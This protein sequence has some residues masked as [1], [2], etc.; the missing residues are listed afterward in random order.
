MNPHI[1]ELFH[2]E[3]RIA[4]LAKGLPQA[5]EMA[6]IEMPGGNPAVGIIRE[7][8]LTGYFITEFGNHI[9]IQ[10]S[11]NKRG[12]DI[13]LHGS[14]LSI[15]TVKRNA[16]VKLLWTADTQKVN[17]EISQSRPKMFDIFLVNIFWE[18]TEDSIFYIPAEVQSEIHAGLG[19]DYY[20]A[21][22]GTNHRGVAISR[23]AMDMLKADS[24]VLK[25]A[26][27]WQKVGLTYSRYD[28]WEA[29]WQNLRS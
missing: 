10:H 24:R 3:P 20:T 2:D 5:F 4:R 16:E 13:S 21:R 15:M 19:E 8:I 18:K 1:I 26:V 29:F 27:S 11:G 9:G 6:D 23:K 14:P 28:R 22:K 25:R 7:F 12:V 17:D